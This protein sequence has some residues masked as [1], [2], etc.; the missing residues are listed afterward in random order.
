MTFSC[1]NMS[2]QC[3]KKVWDSRC[4]SWQCSR[5][6]KENSEYCW[7]HS[8]EYIERQEEIT[9]LRVAKEVE[10]GQRLLK[11]RAAGGY[12]QDALY[13]ILEGHNDPRALA[14]EVLS[15]HDPDWEN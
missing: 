9:R 8:P 4:H 14:E 6:A 3:I 12:Y 5:N 13:K 2:K 15:Q 11:A 7:Q 10:N 1:V